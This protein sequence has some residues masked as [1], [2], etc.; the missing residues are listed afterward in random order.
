MAHLLPP[1]THRYTVMHFFGGIGGGAR[2][3]QLAHARVGQLQATAHTLGS[4]DSDPDACRR[5]ARLTG[6]PSTCLDLFSRAQY[7]AF[8]GNA[9]PEDWREATVDDVRAASGGVLPDIVFLSAP[10]KGFSGLN[11]HRSTQRKYVALNQ[12]TVRSIRLMLEAYAD[13]PPRLI[14]F[15]NV[16]RIQTV[17]RKLLD[18][19]IAVLEAGGY[20]VAETTHDCGEL[21]GL[22]QHRQRFLLVAR[23]RELVPP[24]MYEPRHVPMQTIGEVIGGLPAPTPDT[25][26][27]HRLPRLQWKTWLRLALIKPGHDWRWL[28][29]YD[30]EDG[31][32][33]GWRLLPKRAWHGGALGVRTMDE[34][35]G[36]VTGES[37]PT[38]GA[39]AVADVRLGCKTS[40]NTGRTNAYRQYGVVTADQPAPAISGKGIGNPGGGA[41]SIA[42][43]RLGRTAFNDVYRVVPWDG[44]GPAVTSGSSPSAGGLCVGDVRFG[45]A[46][47]TN[48]SRSG[49]AHYGVLSLDDV[50]RA[51]AA[52]GRHDNGPWSIADEV[53][54]ELPSPRTKCAPLI[55]SAWDAWH[56]P[57][58]TLEAAML[59]G[60][61]VDEIQ[62]ALEGATQTDARGWIGNAVPPPSAKAVAEEFLLTLALADAG[63]SFRLDSRPIWVRPVSLA[64]AVDQ[65]EVRP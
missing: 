27:L 1:R 54:A 45:F 59:Q 63:Q 42:D 2:G 32:L 16:P 37:L 65:P 44:D 57:I 60:F 13:A 24:Y 28:E 35:H 64:L 47:R 49:V 15:E 30:Y 21:G 55:V 5:F 8:H 33:Q 23:H 9:P 48:H 19:I 38:N 41:Y 50:S 29:R 12:L 53:P 61:D 3:F 56:R 36:T 14:V 7:E 31:V 40:S 4:I 34:P 6:V 46:G 26:G 18:E 52:H 25:R 39:H 62:H 58:T 10:C 22:A 51:V 11:A 20:A 43:V 17:G